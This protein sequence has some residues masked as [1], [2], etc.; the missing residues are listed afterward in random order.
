MRFAELYAGQVIA[1]GPVSL[2]EREI[3]EFARA[4]DPQWFHTD[5]EAA[6]RS[7]WGGLIASGWH[8]CA[9]AMKLAYEHVLVG[10]ESIGSP[11]L[12]YLN[13]PSPVRP[14]DPLTMRMDVLEVRRSR[15][16]PELGILRWRWRLQH[17][18]GRDALDLEA[19]SLFELPV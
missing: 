6:A 16:K 18:D 17:T 13:W 1:V 11:G 2:S 14:D 12:S 8:T 7:R 5:A 10:S 4:Y 9:L 15:S 19:T 3:T